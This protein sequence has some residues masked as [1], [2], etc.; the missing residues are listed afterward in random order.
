MSLCSKTNMGTYLTV[1]M[2]H[3]V[4]DVIW[5]ILTFS[6][7]LK[8]SIFQI[9]KV[10]YSKTRNTSLLVII[11][12]SSNFDQIPFFTC[13]WFW[14]T[15]GLM[16]RRLVIGLLYPRSLNLKC[17]HDSSYFLCYSSLPVKLSFSRIEQI[18]CLVHGMESES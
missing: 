13:V 17:L 10:L 2:L 6:F 12:K 7:S 18:G 9:L 15:L 4:G 8:L 11:S 5:W 14:C 3:W 1:C 16:W